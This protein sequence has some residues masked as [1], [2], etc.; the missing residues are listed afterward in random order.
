LGAAFWKQR[1]IWV[2][3]VLFAVAFALLSPYVLIEFQ[4]AI[5]DIASN[6]EVLFVRTQA[7][8]GAVGAGGEQI[9]LLVTLGAG[10]LMTLA[11]L[12]GA[13]VMVGRSWRIA[14]LLFA[15]P[16]AFSLMLIHTWPYGRLQNVLYPFVAIAAAVAIDRWAARAARPAAVALALTMACAAQ[17]LAYDVLLDRL[18]ARVDTRTDAAQWI[19]AN[20][21]AGSGVAVDVYSVPLE[22]TRE[23]LQET[24]ARLAPGEPLGSRA[25]GLLNRDPYPAAAY[26]LFYLGTGGLDKDKAYLNPADVFGPGG[27]A[28][29]RRSGVSHVVIKEAYPHEAD[30]ARTALKAGATLVFRASPFADVTETEADAQLPDYDVRP[31]L[32]VVRPGPTI[33]VWRLAGSGDGR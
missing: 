32:N 6:N 14:A 33:E 22:P 21:A 17:P 9:L 16:A 19:A 1:G 20:V 13:V 18:F 10:I 15:F 29:L 4:T 12:A 7:K 3:T 30:A 28:L 26:R 31:S 8:Y 25:R 2:A 11:A 5:R 23:W 27:F 24:I